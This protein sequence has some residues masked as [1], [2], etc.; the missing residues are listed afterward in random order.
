[1]AY[2]LDFAIVLGS[3]KTGLT[4]NAQ[5]VDTA[6]ADT[7]AA[8]NSGF[9]EIGNGN[10]LLHLTTI[11]DDHRGGI[12]FYEDG[13]PGTIL[14]FAAINPEEAENLDASVS[15]LPTIT[16]ILSGVIEGTI[17]LQQALRLALAVLVGK[18]SGGGTFTHIY[19]DTADSKNRI[20]ATVDANG[21]RTAMTLDE[22]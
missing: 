7:G 5:I 19:R 13:V 4:L 11:P 14:A 21:N 18:S 8:I 12:K 17:T 2:T 20:I 6:G 3:T 9:T 15:S 10:Y 16:D 22:T 1:M